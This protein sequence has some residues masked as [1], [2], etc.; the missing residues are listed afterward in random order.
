MMKGIG[1]STG[2]ALGK[3]FVVQNWEWTLPDKMIDVSDL[4]LEYQRL[5]DGIQSSKRELQVIKQDI[6]DVIGQEQSH[7]FDAHLAILEDP[8]FMKEIEG[9]IEKQY[10]VAEVAVKEVIDKF[11][12]MF[13]LIDDEYMRERAADIKDVGNRLLKHLLGSIE[14]ESPFPHQPYILVT[15]ELSPSQLAHLDPNLVEGIVTTLGGTTSHTA[16]MCRAMSLPFV[17][18]LEG[19]LLRPIQTGDFLIV[20]GNE[21]TVYINP[22]EATKEKYLARKKEFLANQ[23]QLLQ[24]AHVTSETKDGMKVE[25]S[26]NISTVKEIDAALANGT[27]GVGLFRTEFLYMDR[28]SMPEEEEQ[29]QVYKQAAEKLNGKPIV[30]R[31]LDI[32][33]DKQLDYLHLP[34]EDNPFLGYRAIRISL[35]RKE[36]FKS[37]MRA[38]VRASAH[39]NVKMMYPMITSLQ[40]VQMANKLFEDVKQELRAEEKPF[41]EDMECGIMIEVPAAALI[42][43]LLAKEVS[44]FSIG[45]NDLVQYVLAVDRMNETVAHLYDPYHPALIRLLKHIADA[46]HS[47]GIPIAV[48]GELAGDPRALPIWLGLGINELSMSV[49]ANLHVKQRVLESQGER[50]RILL[51][52]LLACSTSAEI[53]TILQQEYAEIIV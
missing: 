22:D 48:C 37:Q 36:Q 6:R 3:A 16:I 31:T 13:D 32:G 1:A 30:I 35:D 34:K 24:L 25:I 29:Y 33:G 11:V 49:Q 52:Q 17:L 46:A 8:V 42:A 2:I 27:A 14:D 28:N 10:K 26:A 23:K 20:D 19:N 50:C 21:G 40:E 43:D 38:I 51:P 7:I 5:Y 47:A 9:I 18:G 41:A 39:G 12:S 15:K 4:A 45:T 44:F 53:L